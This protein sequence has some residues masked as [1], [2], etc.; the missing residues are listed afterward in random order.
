MLG[1][2]RRQTLPPPATPPTP[3]ASVGS[4]VHDRIIVATVAY[5]RSRFLRPASPYRPTLP[6]CK[7]DADTA[8]LEGYLDSLVEAMRPGCAGSEYN[9]LMANVISALTKE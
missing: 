6:G 7:G 2:F 4:A 5:G 3:P 8:R 1:L 9:W